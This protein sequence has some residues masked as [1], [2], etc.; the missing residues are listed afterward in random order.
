[1]R[2]YWF[3]IDEYG[4]PNFFDSAE[5]FNYARRNYPGMMDGD[6]SIYD[7]F[8]AEDVEDCWKLE[9]LW[10]YVDGHRINR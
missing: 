3:I 10:E 9:D 2:D 4:C 8:R 6:T 1:M 5:A 7:R